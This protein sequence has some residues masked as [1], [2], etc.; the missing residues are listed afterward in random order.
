MNDTLIQAEEDP[1]NASNP[2]TPR[3]AGASDP[4]LVGLST[5]RSYI[6][7]DSRWRKLSFWGLTMKLGP[8]ISF[9]W[10][11]ALGITK[12]RRKAAKITGIPTT[13]SGRQRKLGKWMGMK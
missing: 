10:K 2:A 7:V 4:F 11:R 1:I 5:W 8:G 13:K 3:M 9:S 6:T 12:V